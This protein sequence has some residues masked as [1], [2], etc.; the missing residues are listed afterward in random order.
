MFAATVASLNNVLMLR[1]DTPLPLAA[2]ARAAGLSY[3]PA[4]HAL[5]TLE[6][7]GLVRRTRRADQDEFAPEISSPY[8]PVAYQTALIDLPVRKVI[9]GQVLYAAYAYGSVSRP[10]GGGPTSDLDLL[11]VARIRTEQIRD[12]IA[13]SLVGALNQRIQ[14][15]IDPWILDPGEVDDLRRQND[16]H[17]AE[18]LAGVRLFGEL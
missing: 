9:P 14:R 13:S 5:T 16:P 1:P 2:L 15:P 4:K 6:K 17:L 18:A 10:G 3:A 11:V 7:K 8:Y 12:G